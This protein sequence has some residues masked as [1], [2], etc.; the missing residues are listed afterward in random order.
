LPRGSGSDS[1]MSCYIER[2]TA[3]GK[4]YIP[5]HAAPNEQIVKFK[6]QSKKLQ[7]ERNTIIQRHEEELAKLKNGDQAEIDKA[8]K[9][10]ESLYKTCSL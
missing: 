9:K 3:D 8:I 4:V 7:D 2:K 6:E 5:D 1:G 10:I